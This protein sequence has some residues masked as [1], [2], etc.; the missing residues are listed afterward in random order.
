M[1]YIPAAVTAKVG[2]QIL[3]AQKNSPAILFGAGVTGVVGTVVLACRATLKVDD[4]LDKA[5]K[6]LANVDMVVG[7]NVDGYNEH[8]AKRDVLTIRVQTGFNIVKLYAPAVGLGI[9]SIAF[10]TKSHNI[11][12]KRNA[13]LTAAYAAVESMFSKYRERVVADV[14]EDKDREY[15]Y[16]SV[17]TK[18][19]VQ[20]KNGSKEIVKK[21]VDPNFDRSGYERFW[22]QLCQDF[23]PTAELNLY[24][25]KSQQNWANDKLRAKGYL[26]L[27]DVYE[28]LGYEPTQA[29]CV[30]GWVLGNG[31]DDN[32]DFGIWDANNEQARDFVNGREGAILLDFNVD[33]VIYDKL[34]VRQ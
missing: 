29:G 21:R 34:A 12:T 24:W 28:M 15:R 7:R 26:L 23:Q 30:V 19:I 5:Q 18:E 4:V 11:L 2:R 9:L 1:K 33:G 20:G 6:D 16:G 8:D 31:G 32:V 13:G 3:V 17:E 25:L 10:L 22:D 14:G 27:N